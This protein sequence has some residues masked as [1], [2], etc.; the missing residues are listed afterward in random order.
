MRLEQ[1]KNTFFFWGGGGGGKLAVGLNSNHLEY[2]K[3]VTRI[4]LGDKKDV[5]VLTVVGRWLKG[6]NSTHCGRE[7]ARG[8]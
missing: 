5:T 2:Y 7:R 4:S 1:R 3:I 8:T 6:H